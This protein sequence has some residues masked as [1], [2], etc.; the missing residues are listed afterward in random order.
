MGGS[1]GV[2]T[3]HAVEARGWTGATD[4]VD[5]EAGD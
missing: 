1:E 5:V 3:E 2:D 4:D